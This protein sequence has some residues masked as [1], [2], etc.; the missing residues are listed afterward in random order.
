MECGWY[1][2]M[3]RMLA[4]E[5][6]MQHPKKEGIHTTTI[7]HNRLYRSKNQAWLTPVEIF[8]PHYSNAIA[9]SV[10]VRMD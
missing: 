5:R 8:A 2:L 7:R 3:M 10:C 1:G 4:P 9:R 6:A